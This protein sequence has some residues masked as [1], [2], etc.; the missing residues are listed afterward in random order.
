MRIGR[1]RKCLEFG[2][3]AVLLLL[4][5]GWALQAEEE[6]SSAADQAEVGLVEN[7]A[8]A[9]ATYRQALTELVHY[10]SR[11]G[12]DAKRKQ[13]QEELDGFDDVVK[14]EYVILAYV[15]DPNIKPTRTIPEADRLY[16][17]GMEYK[18]YRTLFFRRSKKKKL[19]L[20]LERFKEI[21]LKHPES[22]KCDDAAYRIAQIYDGQHFRDPV[23][24]VK[25]YEKCFEWDPR[26]PY[27][28][29]YCAARIYDLKLKDPDTAVRVYALAVE[30]E[31]DE[32][33]REKAENRLAELKK[34]L[35]AQEAAE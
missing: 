35:E 26:T 27:D 25:Y 8:E 9:R 31:R 32:R 19:Q 24:A 1:F 33:I 18:N 17:D 12:N 22:D 5:H 11:I 29:R 4:L 14:H 20:A 15:V 6:K 2:L 34:K 23:L 13:A 16:K 7:V 3:V 10:Y 30:K 28:A 21:L